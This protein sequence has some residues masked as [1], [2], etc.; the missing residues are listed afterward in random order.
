MFAAG[1]ARDE[2]GRLVTA[3]G[4]VLAVTGLGDDLADAR[5]RAYAAAD[6]VRWPG[7]TRRE[8]IARAASAG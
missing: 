8:D 3:G 7:L 6:L 5:S 1:V 2:G 4:R